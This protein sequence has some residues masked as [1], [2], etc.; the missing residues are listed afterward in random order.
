MFNFFKKSIED[1]AKDFETQYKIAKIIIFKYL[2]IWFKQIFSTPEWKEIF[3]DKPKM[4]TAMAAEV[5][6]NILALNDTRNSEELK[7]NEATTM[8]KKYVMKWSDDVMNMDKD[9]CDFVIQT[10]QMDSVFNQYFNS[11]D[12]PFNDPRGKKVFEIIM[13]YS[14]KV[15][16]SPD[17]KK[18]KKLLKKWMSWDAM[19]DE[20]ITNK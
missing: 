8:A 17:P 1:N 12:W 4:H 15:P 9:F 16:E 14:G 7:N 11:S 6:R 18:Y 13:K 19:T 10:L 20:K 3:S 5:M 2:D